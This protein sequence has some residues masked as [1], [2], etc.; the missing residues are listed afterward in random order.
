M[1]VPYLGNAMKGWTRRSNITVI[2]QTIVDHEVTEAESVIV[3]PANLQP[4]PAAQVARKPEEQRT[5]KWW[6]VFIIDRNI[7]LETDS[8][9]QDETGQQFRIEKAH[10]WR[11]SGFTKYEAI[12]DYT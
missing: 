12:E 4:M 8:I 1:P 6:T 2:T 10:D 9:I 3:I 11:T 7:F 5:W